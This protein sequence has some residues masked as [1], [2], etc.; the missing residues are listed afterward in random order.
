[1]RNRTT[2]IL[3]GLAWALAF[4]GTAEAQAPCDNHTHGW[5]GSV[6][7]HWH[8]TFGNGGGCENSSNRQQ[9]AQC[10]WDKTIEAFKNAQY[11]KPNSVTCARA[12][13]ASRY[14]ATLKKF[15]TIA[16]DR[17]DSLFNSYNRNW[18][19]TALGN[20]KSPQGTIDRNATRK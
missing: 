11:P 6:K 9:A 8:G 1:M 5:L 2:M 14:D 10:A 13:L 7:N 17:C 3:G 15:D 18:F 16:Q 19:Q 20:C 12:W 4:S